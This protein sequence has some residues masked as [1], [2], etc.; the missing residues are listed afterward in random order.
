MSVDRLKLIRKSAEKYNFKNNLQKKTKKLMRPNAVRKM[1][2]I[3]I[4]QDAETVNSEYF[5]YREK[6]IFSESGIGETYHLTTMFDS[7]Y[8]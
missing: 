2:K 4:P 3:D 1:S 8:R 7:E 5:T 6:Q